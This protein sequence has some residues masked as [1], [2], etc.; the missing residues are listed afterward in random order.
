MKTALTCVALVA[1][2]L[3]LGATPASAQLFNNPVYFS[4]S[5]GTGLSLN[6]EYARG[7]SDRKDINFAGA[8]GV[9]GL[10]PVSIM[11]G[12]GLAFEGGESEA[13]FGGA[14][15]LN[16]LDL[17]LVPV[18]VNVQG[19]I[20]TLSSEGITQLDIPIGVGVAFSVPAPILDVEPWI[21]PR[22]HIMRLSNGTSLTETGYGVSAGLN[23][24]L[25]TGFG[26]HVAADYVK[27]SGF[28][29]DAFTVGAGFHYRIAIPGLVPGGLVK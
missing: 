13:T 11:G 3:G 5:H 20:G 10:G 9:L 14:V 27:V 22:L 17:P 29:F 2:A 4:P 19:G 12:A 16:I 7:F 6:G 28:D 18:S 21:A 23:V 1:L 24:T 25:P 26:F 8:R 15:A